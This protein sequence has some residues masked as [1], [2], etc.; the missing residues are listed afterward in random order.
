M[1]LTGKLGNHISQELPGS[2]RYAIRNIQSAYR[3]IRKSKLAM[4]ATVYW[5]ILIF[6]AIFG[7]WLAP[8]HYQE[9]LPVQNT[10]P[11]LAYPLGTTDLGYDVLSRLI[12]G[13]RPTVQTG[14]IGG[15]MI[16][17]IG[18]TI[19]VTSGYVGGKLDDVLMRF[20]DI[21]Y[22]APLIPTAIVLMAVFGI[23]FWTSIFV[24]GVILWRG[25]AR[26]LRS[27]TLQIKERPYVRAAKATGASTPHIIIKHI[28]P[29]VAPMAM[30]Y[31]ALGVGG[32]I[33][34]QAGLAFLGLSDPA[35]P[36]WGTMI[37][38]AYASGQM[39]RLWAWSITPGLMIALTV[40]A[41]FLLGREFEVTGAE[42]AD[43]EQM[44]SMGAR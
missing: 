12:Y 5:I 6:V 33:L 15:T 2:S 14:L 1:S 38:N 18:L 17:S 40:L 16:I 35:V 23:G 19:G 13:A 7:P 22:S 30:L 29:N 42:D 10:G 34:V 43:E 26:V 44:A 31:F 28:L 36:A 11:S 8:Y 20:T 37:E 39:D 25:S 32:A 21:A 3:R 41:T 24:I 9:F 4:F 27:Q